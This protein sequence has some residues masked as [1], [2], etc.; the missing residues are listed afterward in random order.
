MSANSM[1]LYVLIR[2]LGLTQTEVSIISDPIAA[3]STGLY[4]I[5]EGD[6]I[7][8]LGSEIEIKVTMNPKPSTRTTVELEEFTARMGR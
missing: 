3:V 2:K 5:D 4:R 1:I 7:Y 8:Q 6:K